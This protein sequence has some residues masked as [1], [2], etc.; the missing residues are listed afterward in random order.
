MKLRG[1]FTLTLALAALVPIAVAAIV[2]RRV[3]ASSYRS[4][5]EA[6][7]QTVEAAV[8][9]SS[10]DSTRRSPRRSPRSPSRHNPFIGI[11]LGEL[12]KAGTLDDGKVLRSLR[13]QG[14]PV[15]RGLS[16]RRCTRHRAR[17]RGPDHA[18]LPRATD[19]EDAK[20]RERAVKTGGK[21]YFVRDTIR[22]G[23]TVETRARRRVGAPR[24]LRRLHR[25]AVGGPARRR[26]VSSTSVRRQGRIDARIVDA[27]G[28]RPAA[29]A[30]T[31][32]WTQARQGSAD[33]KA[34][35]SA[36]TASRSRSSR[37]RSPTEIST[38]CS[39]TSR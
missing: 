24:A 18:A 31:A 37:S 38:S 20:V 4:D 21:P 27:G 39:A 32:D 22:T 35:A 30:G 17:R 13:E 12:G 7:R 3:I 23:P 25:G 9:A 19:D 34:A 8:G 36:R 16:L 6:T 14:G 33:P 11:L 28:H 5:Y 26:A 1:R 29:A 10:S 2:T 15:M